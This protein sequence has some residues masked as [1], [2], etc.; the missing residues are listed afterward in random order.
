MLKVMIVDD[1]M[2]VRIG[3]Q[4]CIN[5]EEHGCQVIFTCESGE[6]AIA[7]FERQVP[8]IVFTDIM[9]PEMDGIQLVEYIRS[10]YPKTKVIVLSCVN[11]IDY[12]KRA[13]KLGAEDYILKLSDSRVTEECRI[14]V[15]RKIQKGQD[16][17]GAFEKLNRTNQELIG[18]LMRQ[19]GEQQKGNK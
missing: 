10:H 5:W 2:I 11:E 19:L 8:D 1:E 14:E 4:S 9:M 12:V 6:E 13:I 17:F 15:E 16:F 18:S 3:I 7:A